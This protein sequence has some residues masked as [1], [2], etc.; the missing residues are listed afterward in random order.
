MPGEKMSDDKK[1]DLL[2]FETF[3]LEVNPK[4]GEEIPPTI[5]TR[6]DGGDIKEVEHYLD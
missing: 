3:V 6:F 5:F 2:L 1:D 4:T